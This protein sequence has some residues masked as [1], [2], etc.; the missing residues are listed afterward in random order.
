[1]T[2][3]VELRAFRNEDGSELRSVEV[4][5][6]LIEKETTVIDILEHVFKYGQ[7]DFQP[8]NQRSVSVGDVVRLY[9]KRWEVDMFG[10]KEAN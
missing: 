2:V 5:N 3:L 6:I 7:N 9:G 10:F 4:P 8:K 1:M